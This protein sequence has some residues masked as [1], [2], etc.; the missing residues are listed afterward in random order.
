L[1][2]PPLTVDF[3]AADVVHVESE[4]MTRAVHEELPVSLR[5]DQVMHAPGQQAEILEAARDLADGR[6]MRVVPVVTDRRDVRRGAIRREHD[7]VELALRL[8]EHAVDGE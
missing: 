2:Q 6:V 5:L 4:P 3:V 7:L 1:Y 8:T